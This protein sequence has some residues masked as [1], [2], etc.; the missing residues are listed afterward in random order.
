MVLNNDA[1]LIVSLKPQWSWSLKEADR[2]VNNW[3]MTIGLISRP[4]DR[5]TTMVNKR[6]KQHQ[7]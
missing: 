6:W 5:L 2:L 4:Y 7:L 3:S 1:L